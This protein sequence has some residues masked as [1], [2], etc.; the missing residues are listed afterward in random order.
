MKILILEDDGFRVRFFIDRFGQYDL[1]ITE[2]AY[3]AIEYLE[4]QV[5]DYIFLDNDLGIGNGEG[6]DV[7]NFLR[8]NPDNLNNYSIV[9]IHSWNIP[10]TKI[11]KSNLPNAVSAPFNTENFSNLRLDI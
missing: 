1:I 3:E 4:T 5:F 11:I 8:S 7:A 9:I 2:N 6:V 10:A